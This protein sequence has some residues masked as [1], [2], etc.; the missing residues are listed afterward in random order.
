MG[1][2]AGVETKFSLQ[3]FINGDGFCVRDRRM[4]PPLFSA[5][6]HG[7]VQKC[8]GF[9]HVVSVSVSSYMS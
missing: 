1:A 8:A 7:L 6:V 3:L 5:L 4:C 9:V 2:L